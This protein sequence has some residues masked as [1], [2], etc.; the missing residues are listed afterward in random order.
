MSLTDLLVIILV[1]GGFGFMIWSR[2]VKRDHPVVQKVKE[3]FKKKEEREKFIDESKW[4][5]PNIE[6]KIY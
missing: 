5:Q 1:F 4:Q 2:L 3:M 6:K